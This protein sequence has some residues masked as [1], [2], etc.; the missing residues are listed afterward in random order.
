MSVHPPSDKSPLTLLL[1]SPPIHPIDEF[2]CKTR[3]FESSNRRFAWGSVRRIARLYLLVVWNQIGFFLDTEKVFPEESI[4]ISRQSQT[5]IRCGKRRYG[6]ALILEKLPVTQGSSIAMN[7]LVMNLQK[8]LELL[9][10]FFIFLWWLFD[11]SLGLQR[12]HKEGLRYQ[13]TGA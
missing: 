6:L 10:I 1:H 9:F 11:A 12:A 13:L 5:P 4:I 8:L 2:I 3:P 7:I